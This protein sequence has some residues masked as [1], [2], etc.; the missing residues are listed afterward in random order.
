[1]TLNPRPHF[2]QSITFFK[3]LSGASLIWS[4]RFSW[5]IVI[6]CCFFSV[7][8]HVYFFAIASSFDRGKKFDA[9]VSLYANGEISVGKN[10]PYLYTLPSLSVYG[11]SFICCI[12]FARSSS[13]S[14]LEYRLFRITLSPFLTETHPKLFVPLSEC[15]QYS[16]LKRLMP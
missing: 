7:I 5:R 10:S 15:A 16:A 3:I 4:G 9:I 2:L 8:L 6:L 13:Y 14:S 1:M 12:I 11:M